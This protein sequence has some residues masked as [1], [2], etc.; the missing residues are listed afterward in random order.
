ME[1]PRADRGPE[2]T[3][4]GKEREGR[5][6]LAGLEP[7]RLGRT[8]KDQ[9]G[10]GRMGWLAGSLAGEHLFCLRSEPLCKTNVRE[11]TAGKTRKNWEGP[12]RT[13]ED[14]VAGSLAG[15]TCLPTVRTHMQTTLFGSHVF[16]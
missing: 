2:R 15:G 9:E 12:G 4:K 14:G 11:R 1:G 8:R 7:G 10:P 5:V 3:R 16:A 13:R 6:G